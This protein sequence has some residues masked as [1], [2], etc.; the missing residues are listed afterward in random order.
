MEERAYL[1]FMRVD[2]GRVFVDRVPSG[3]SG[4]LRKLFGLEDG[5]PFYA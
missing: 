2:G 4:Y 1:A 5:T 3:K